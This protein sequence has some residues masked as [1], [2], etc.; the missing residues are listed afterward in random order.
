LGILDYVIVHELAH[1]RYK[2]HGPRFWGEVGKVLP[3][4]R[5]RRK[6]LKENGNMLGP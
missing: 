6:W 4:Y 5:E 1:S 3:D 2:S